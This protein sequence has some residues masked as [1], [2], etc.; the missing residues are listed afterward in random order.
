MSDGRK[1]EVLLTVA[2]YDIIMEACDQIMA[3]WKE[4]G[5]QR[6]SNRSTLKR[7]VEKLESAWDVGIRS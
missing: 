1:F 7:A 5:I 4:L 3:E 6:S 2:Q